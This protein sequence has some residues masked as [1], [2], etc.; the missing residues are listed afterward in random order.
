MLS[1][2]SLLALVERAAAPPAGARRSSVQQV[3]D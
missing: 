3:A 1:V 2:I